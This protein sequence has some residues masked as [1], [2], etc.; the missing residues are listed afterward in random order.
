MIGVEG[1]DVT[2]ITT[3]VKLQVT[4][5]RNC[6]AI[7]LADRIEVTIPCPE[8]RIRGAVIPKPEIRNPKPETRN[9][10]P[11]TRNPTAETRNPIPETPNPKPQTLNPKPSTPNPQPQTRNPKP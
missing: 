2:K 4:S 6:V 5:Q 7:F 8:I 10:K 3:H 9:P 1:N 11:E